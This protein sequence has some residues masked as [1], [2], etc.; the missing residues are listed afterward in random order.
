MR[1]SASS[2]RLLSGNSIFYSCFSDFSVNLLQLEQ[3][4]KIAKIVSTKWVNIICPLRSFD[5]TRDNEMQRRFTTI[6]A[7]AIEWE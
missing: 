3:F 5:D 4:L 7:F 1:D 2:E 6:H